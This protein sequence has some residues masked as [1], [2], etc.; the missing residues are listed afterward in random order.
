MKEFV[1]G[2]SKKAANILTGVLICGPLVGGTLVSFE[3][4]NHDLITQILVGVNVVIGLSLAVYVM[5]V[6][7]KNQK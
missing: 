2:L 1:L 5:R 3:G 7:A 6:R 4:P